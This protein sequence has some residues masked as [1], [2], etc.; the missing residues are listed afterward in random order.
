MSKLM[1]SITQQYKIRHITS[2]PYHPHENGQVE[3]TNKVLEAILI[4][5]IQSN[6]KDWAYRLPEAL[7]SYRTTWRNTN[8]HTPY[9]LVYGKQVLLPI[10]FQIKTFRMETQ[11]GMDLLEAH[12]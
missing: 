9:E 11:L 3:S 12:K 4:K 6:H 8:G 5:T 10:K 1:K 2:S 7:L